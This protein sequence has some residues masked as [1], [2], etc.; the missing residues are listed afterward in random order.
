[1]GN[2]LSPFLANLFRSEFEI[3]IT[4]SFPWMYKSWNK[5]INVF[6]I[7]KEKHLDDSPKLL[8]IQDKNINFTMEI[9][10]N[11]YL[12]FLNLK[13]IKNNKLGFGIFKKETYALNYIKAYT[14]ILF[15][16]ICY[17]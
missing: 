4:S 14:T 15:P 13:L 10:N 5:Y 16:L 12:P 6:C 11:N 17:N 3:H 1:M 2:S 8:N 7:V 9:E